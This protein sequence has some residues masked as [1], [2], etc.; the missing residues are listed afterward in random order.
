MGER[1]RE[2]GSY[3]IL[4]EVEGA[5]VKL[6][7]EPVIVIHFG[8]VSSRVVRISSLLQYNSSFLVAMGF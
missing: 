4:D 1:E 5:G 3:L 2:G 7:T 8:A 6:G